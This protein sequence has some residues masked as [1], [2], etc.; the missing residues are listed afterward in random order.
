MQVLAAESTFLTTPNRASFPFF[1]V[2]STCSELFSVFASL[3][4]ISIT[5]WTKSSGQKSLSNKFLTGTREVEGTPFSKVLSCHSTSTLVWV[6]TITA[7]FC[8]PAWGFF[9]CCCCCF[10]F[11]LLEALAVF[12]FDCLWFI[13]F[14]ALF[15]PLDCL[16]CRFSELVVLFSCFMWQ[17]GCTCE[18]LSIKWK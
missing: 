11:S 15:V 10:R 18:I 16:S 7:Q 6:P 9:R 3:G 12:W 13:C 8:D 14:L 4:L 5:S 17:L 1:P 2:S